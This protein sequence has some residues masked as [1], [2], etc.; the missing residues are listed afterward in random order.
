V[1]VSGLSN[2][3]AIAAAGDNSYALAEDGTVWAWGDNS[4]AQ[5]GNPDARHTQNTP[6]RVAGLPSNVATIA[7]GGTH[8]LAVTAD[9][10][11]WAWGNNNTGQ[12][13]DGAQCGKSCQT[14]IHVAEITAGAAIAG[15]YVHTLATDADGNVYG[16]GANG[17]GQLGDGTTR[18]RTTPVRTAGLDQVTASPKI[19]T[20]YT[21]NGDGLRQSATTTGRTQQFAWDLTGGLPLL[22]NDGDASYLYGPGGAPVAQ[23]NSDGTTTYLHADQLGSTR[24]I[25]GA[26]GTVAA[27]YSYS[28]HGKT[29]TKTGTAQTTLQW[30]GQYHDP[31]TGLYYMR[32]RYYDTTTAQFLTRDPLVRI[33]GAAYSYAN[34]DP[35]NWADPTGLCI[36]CWSTVEDTLHTVHNIAGTVSTVATTVVVVAS[37]ATAVCAVCAPVTGTVA[38]F[39]GTVALTA[40]AVSAVTQAGI[41]AFDCYDS[42]DSRCLSDAAAIGIDLVAHR[43][44][45]Q[46]ASAI[47]KLPGRRAVRR[48]LGDAARGASELAGEGLG[49]LTERGIDSYADSRS[50][51]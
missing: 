13:G 46:A 23:I 4:Y 44:G 50:D 47:W 1:Q 27:T 8:A 3:T 12:L 24:L 16:W 39:A 15:G 21:Y 5:L 26:D 28:P 33:T 45:E 18:V 34:G 51:C 48:N 7:A 2:I 40:G 32:A 36:L 6:V 49:Y 14:P 35:V 41:T 11:V 29:I 38:G 30:A 37:V 42:L 17:S 31:Q 43:A 19:D 22:L 20:N 10:E 25:T 9:G